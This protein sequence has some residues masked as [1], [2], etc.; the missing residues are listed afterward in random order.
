MSRPA[1]PELLE[2]MSRLARIAEALPECELARDIALVVVEL[3]LDR[4]LIR[5][6]LAGG[7]TE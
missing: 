7:A 2:A 1:S 3:S 6:T 5:P 4:E